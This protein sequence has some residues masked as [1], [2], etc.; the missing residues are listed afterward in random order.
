LGEKKTEMKNNEVASKT[1][2][3]P[4]GTSHKADIATPATDVIVPMIAE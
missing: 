1:M 3:G 4:E 2:A